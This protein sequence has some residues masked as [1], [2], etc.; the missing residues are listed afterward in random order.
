MEVV[1]V[2]IFH[3]SFTVSSVTGFRAFGNPAHGGALG[4]AKMCA[5][6]RRALPSFEHLRGY[7]PVAFDYT[8]NLHTIA[9][10]KR[11]IEDYV[12]ADGE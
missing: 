8:H 12:V 11:L 1:Q 10:G 5:S 7:V 3:A 4:L 2:N 6:F 9:A